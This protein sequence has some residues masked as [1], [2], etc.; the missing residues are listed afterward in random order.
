MS[1]YTFSCKDSEENQ[2]S[3]TRHDTLFSG[4]KNSPATHAEQDKK[5]PL[6]NEDLYLYSSVT[7]TLGK[8]VPSENKHP[9]GG[10]KLESV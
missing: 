6:P 2:Y 1:D 5:C 9:H 3:N 7:E 10:Y 4:P 8:S